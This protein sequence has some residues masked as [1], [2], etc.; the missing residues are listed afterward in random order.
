MKRKIYF[1]L[2]RQ[3]CC[4]FILSVFCISAANAQAKIQVLE[5]E[6]RTAEQRN[7]VAQNIKEAARV[8]I[9]AAQAEEKAAR[10][11]AKLGMETQ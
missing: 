9:E 4:C 10:A 7:V 11:K 3:I 2:F 8:R 1:I 6:A 5:A